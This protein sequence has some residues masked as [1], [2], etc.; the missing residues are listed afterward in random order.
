MFPPAFAP[1]MGYL[2]KYLPA[3]GWEPVIITEYIPEHINDELVEINENITYINYYWSDNKIIQKLKYTFTFFADFFFDYKNVAIRKAAKKQIEK[4][5]ISLILSST[6]RIFPM[7]AAYQLSKKYKLPIV[8]DLRDIVEQFPNNEHISKI[9]SNSELLNNIFS[10]IITRKILRQRN[11]MIRKSDYITTVSEFHVK[12][13]Q[14]YNKHV[15]LIYNGFDPELFFPE[16]KYPKTFNIVYAGRILSVEMEDPTL[17]FEAIYNL[18]K[19]GIVTSQMCRIKFYTNN[20][21][22]NIVQELA[23]KYQIGEFIDNYDIVNSSLIPGILNEAS[24]LLLLTN[25]HETGSRG[26]MTT[27]YFEYLAV[28][29]PVLCVRNDEDCLEKSMKETQS[30]IAASD[31][32]QVENFILEKYAEWK[33]NGYTRQPVNQQ[34]IQQFS[35]REQAKQFVS[36]FESLIEK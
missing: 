13:L 34:I 2:C 23:Q 26:I 8:M 10:N 5:N 3:Y 33:Q 32:E 36:I 1:R 11:E 14:K 9:L 12:T 24:V 6:Y 17:L 28:E 31:F 18:S 35:R 20:K 15:G 30:G 21:T 25:K 27:K 29:K 4:H 19:K 7:K 16:I 22:K